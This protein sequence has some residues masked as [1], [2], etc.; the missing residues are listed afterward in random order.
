[1]PLPYYLMRINPKQHQPIK[2][3]ETK[4]EDINTFVYLGAT[5]SK[6]GGGME[7]LKGRIVKAR[8][9]FFKLKKIWNA[10]FLNTRTKLQLYKTLVIPVL[11]Y[12]CETWKMNKGDEKMIDIFQNNNLRKI[13]KV[14]WQEKVTTTELFYKE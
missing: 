9:V 14:R 11:L 10:S 12:G 2:V 1:M 3:S 13:I 5:V 8:I 4:L 7:D 6:Q